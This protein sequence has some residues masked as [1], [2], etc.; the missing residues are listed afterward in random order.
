M[1]VPLLG[2]ISLGRRVLR[3][4]QAVEGFMPQRA[5]FDTALPRPLRSRAAPLQ[6]PFSVGDSCLSLRIRGIDGQRALGRI[7]GML[8]GLIGIPSFVSHRVL[9]L[10][11]ERLAHREV[12]KEIAGRSRNQ[13]TNIFG[14]VSNE[15]SRLVRSAQPPR[16]GGEF[17][18]GG[19]Q[20]PA[21]LTVRL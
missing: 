6:T 13:G 21:N 16:P 19:D 9:G 12:S 10:V 17:A 3:I 15:S 2:A 18:L 1:S 14:H 5:T 8:Q 20:I 11:N 4:D 7:E